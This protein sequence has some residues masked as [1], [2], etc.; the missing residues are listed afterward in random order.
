MKVKER[1][2]RTTHLHQSLETKLNKICVVVLLV[3]MLWKGNVKFRSFHSMIFIVTLKVTHVSM[4]ELIK[5]VEANQHYYNPGSS[6]TV[7]F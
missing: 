3:I 6:T 1:G 4:I 2:V 7:F 5:S